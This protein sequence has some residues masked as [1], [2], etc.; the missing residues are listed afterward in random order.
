MFV[1]AGT[2]G[3]DVA[4]W[5]IIAAILIFNL[6]ALLNISYYLSVLLLLASMPAVLMT[7]VMRDGVGCMCGVVNIAMIVFA[8]RVKSAS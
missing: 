5:L 2:Y 7:E 4:V 1:L 6:V 8:K 3:F